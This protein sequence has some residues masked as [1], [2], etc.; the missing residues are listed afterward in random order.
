MPERV[1]IK[2]LARLTGASVASV[3]RALHGAEGVGPE[4]RQRI[5]E[6]ARRSNYRLDEQA[7]L[8]RRDPFNIVALLPKP[9]GNERFYYQG[10]WKGVYRACEDLEKLKANVTCIETDFGVDDMAS[11]LEALYDRSEGTGKPIDGLL[12]ICD[13]AASRRWIE[14]FIRRGTRV[15]LVDRG[16]PVEDVS[17]IVSG[18]VSDIAQVA[19]EVV[20]LLRDRQ[21]ALP[22]LLVNGSGKRSSYQTYSQA[23]RDCIIAMDGKCLPELMELNAE[24]ESTAR[25][26]LADYLKR[27]PLGGII[28]ASARSTYWVCDEVE[29]QIDDPALRP[30]I[31]GT[32]VFAEQQPFFESGTLRATICQSHSTFGTRALQYLVGSLINL[33]AEG[34]AQ[35]HEPVSIVMKNNYRFFL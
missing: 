22:I 23:V 2:D 17:C 8:L 15:A 6:A 25:E 33:D 20:D 1:T 18:P 35:F 31:V 16:E 10:L 14:R 11:A 26:A 5:L 3:H 21:K 27:V 24:E 13:D 12:T 9:V 4:L 29:K 34:G 19:V 32:D 7:S 30:P 28:A